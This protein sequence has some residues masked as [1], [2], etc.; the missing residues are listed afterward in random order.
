MGQLKSRMFSV[1]TAKSTVT[2]VNSKS[3]TAIGGALSIWY[4]SFPGNAAALLAGGITIA[5]GVTYKHP[6][7]FSGVLNVRSD[8]GTVIMHEVE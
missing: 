2:L 5:D 8:A 4:G 1:T 6:Q 7:A 3:I